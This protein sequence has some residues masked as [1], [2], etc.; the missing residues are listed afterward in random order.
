MLKVLSKDLLKFEE[1]D[2]AALL[3]QV[4]IKDK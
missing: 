2:L 4:E 1:V 3:L